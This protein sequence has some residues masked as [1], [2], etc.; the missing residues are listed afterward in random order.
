[1]KR[2]VLILSMLLVLITA[3]FAVEL[4]INYGVFNL[5]EDPVII[6][7]RTLVPLRDIA[8]IFGA[9]VNWY[10]DNT[11]DVIKDGKE[12]GLKIGSRTVNNDGEYEK[13]DVAPR[14]INSTT[15]VPIRFIAENLGIEIE[16]NQAGKY[17]NIKTNDKEIIERAEI[18]SRGNSRRKVLRGKV[19][20]VD[21]GHGG[22]QTGAS[23]GG[24]HEKDLNLAIAK[25][26]KDLLVAQG[27]TVY[28]TRSTD[29]TTS[30][31]ARTELANNKDADLFVSIHNNATVTGSAYSGTEVLYKAGKSYSNGMS[32]YSFAETMRK[33]L[34]AKIDTI[35]RGLKD[36]QDLYVLN[37][38]NMPAVLV[39]VGY[40]TN[41]TELKKLNTDSF[42]MKVA[43]GITQGVVNV[44]K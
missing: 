2:I 42:Q 11:I 10:K 9:K 33:A 28:M 12:I 37:R 39:E 7:G 25:K 32:N 8:E 19:I 21:P 30:L 20:V 13:L 1:M 38:T 18:V 14:L 15:M 6:E 3:S 29:V 34:M 16:W 23:Y 17:V 44:Y 43:Q 26:V 31:G 5:A 41:P 40:M 4:K 22:S 27:A 35:D 36:R 24:I